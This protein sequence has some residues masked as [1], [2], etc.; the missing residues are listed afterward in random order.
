[1]K[2]QAV[3]TLLVIA[4]SVVFAASANATL[5]VSANGTFN[6]PTDINTFGFHYFTSLGLSVNIQTWGYGGTA[7]APGGTNLMGM[8]ILPGG[9]DPIITLY[10][11]VG[12]GGAVIATNDDGLCP[13]GTPSD[14]YCRDSTI[15]VTGLTNNADYT[16][17]L[18]VYDTTNFTSAF[19][20][21][22]RN[23]N[24]ALDAQAVP[25]PMTSMLLGSGLLALGWLAHRKRR[26]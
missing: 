11:G 16:I 19:D 13:P 8:V 21:S 9:F 12:T 10:A 24:W 20:G 26:S 14:T 17:A 6:N 25:E 22:T 7:G 4:L 2:R 5:L 18:R 3:Q 23:G 15:N 1:M